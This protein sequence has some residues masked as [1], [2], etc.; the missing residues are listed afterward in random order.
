MRLCRTFKKISTT[1]L[2]KYFLAEFEG[3]SG[4][5]SIVFYDKISIR[6]LKDLLAEDESISLIF[7]NA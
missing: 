1:E 4:Q 7:S 3:E 2:E 5:F 6:G